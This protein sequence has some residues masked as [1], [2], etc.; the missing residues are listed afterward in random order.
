VA[1]NGDVA[2]KVGTYPLALAAQ[3]AGI[4]F[5]VAGPSSTID[6]ACDTGSDIVIEQRDPREVADGIPARNPA[7]DVT[8]AALVTALVTERGILT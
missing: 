1:A 4:P 3:A 6:P 7:F 5:V 8:P 2:N